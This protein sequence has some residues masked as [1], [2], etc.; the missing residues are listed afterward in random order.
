M[1]PVTQ[2]VDAGEIVVIPEVAGC[3]IATSGGSQRKALQ[4]GFSE[5]QLSAVPAAPPA[6]DLNLDCLADCGRELQGCALLVRQAAAACVLDCRAA[7][8]RLSCL[9]GRIATALTGGAVCG[10]E[11]DTCLSAWPAPLP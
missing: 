3:T 11:F 6:P 1:G 10:D 5:G 4:M 7:P 9:R 8:D 2:A